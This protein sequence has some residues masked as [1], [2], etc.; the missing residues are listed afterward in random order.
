M[1]GRRADKEIIRII[2]NFMRN[3][4]EIFLKKEGDNWFKRNKGTAWEGGRWDPPL[5]LMEQ[6]SLRPK[7]VL[8]IGCSNGWRLAEIIKKHHV[9]CVGVEPSPLAIK[10]GKKK[11]SKVIFKRGIASSLPLEETF[12]LVIINFVLHWV[13]R[14]FLFKVIA[15]IDRVVADEGYLIIGDFLPDNP[16]KVRYHHLPKEEVYTYKQDYTQIFTVSALYQ[17]VATISFDHEK[18]LLSSKT[19]SQHRGGCSLLRKS[20]KYNFFSF[21]N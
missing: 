6:Y 3:P 4:E 8:E 1:A 12:D 21:P 11:N 18:Y 7:R 2:I 9:K 15:E 5:Y 16:T 20:S 14:E 17:R 13:S 19:N 10:E